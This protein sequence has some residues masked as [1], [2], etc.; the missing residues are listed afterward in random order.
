MYISCI[1]YIRKTCPDIL[2]KMKVKKRV[3]DK[4]IGKKENGLHVTLG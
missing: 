4:G 1:T 2:Q 3:R